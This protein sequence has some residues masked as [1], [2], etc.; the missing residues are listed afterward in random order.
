VLEL[1]FSLHGSEVVRDPD[2]VGC[3]INNFLVYSTLDTTIEGKKGIHFRQ[4]EE[5]ID[6]LLKFVSIILV[7]E[8]VDHVMEQLSDVTIHDAA[9]CRTKKGAEN[10]RN[11]FYIIFS[12]A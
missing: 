4:D 3:E 6:H 5:I 11:K 1:K 12:L 8:S 10:G 2:L 7:N 9:A